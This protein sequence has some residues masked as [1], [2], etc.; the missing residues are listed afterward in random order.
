MK[1]QTHL[2]S[3]LLAFITLLF[4]QESYSQQTQK[5]PSNNSATIQNSP[6]L[7]HTYTPPTNPA[8]IKDTDLD[9]DTRLAS[10]TQYATVVQ[11]VNLLVTKI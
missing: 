10:K 6:V 5:D 8:I 7:R 1:R 4:Y 9:S 11:M 2:V 3:F